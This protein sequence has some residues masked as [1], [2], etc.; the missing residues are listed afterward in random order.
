MVSGN[1]Q[2]REEE[3]VAIAAPVF[4]YESRPLLRWLL[5][6]KGQTFLLINMEIKMG[7]Q[8]KSS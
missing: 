2:E 5:K 3:V 7:M 4:D 1:D 8:L 6:Q